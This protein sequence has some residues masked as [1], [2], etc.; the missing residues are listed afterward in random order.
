MAA[1]NWYDWILLVVSVLLI[2]VI[3]LQNSKDDISSAFSGEKSDLFANQKQRGAEKVINDVTAILSI[4][5]FVLTIVVAVVP[6][7]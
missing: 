1:L 3:V 4:V 2:I 6:R 7:I 5:F